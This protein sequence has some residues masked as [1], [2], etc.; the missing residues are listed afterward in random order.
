MEGKI[1]LITNLQVQCQKG[2]RAEVVEMAKEALPVTVTKD[3]C[4]RYDLCIGPEDE[5]KL[6][7][8]GKWES[9]AHFDAYFQCR[10]ETG[11]FDALAPFLAGEPVIRA[12]EIEESF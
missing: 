2:K 7:L 12:L 5:G 10:A 4:H 3:G 9:K 11:F 8:F 1:A 6:E